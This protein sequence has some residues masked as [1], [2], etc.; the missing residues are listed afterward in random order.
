MFK[1]FEQLC[2]FSEHFFQN[3]A[4]KDRYFPQTKVI[5]KKDIDFQLAIKV[6]SEL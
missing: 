5:L 1:L 3:L 2:I 4:N 6:E